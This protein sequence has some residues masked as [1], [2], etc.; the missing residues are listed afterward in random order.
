M[1]VVTRRTGERIVIGTTIRVEVL[2]V[3]G[4][5]VRIGIQ[6][7]RGVTILRQELLD[8]EVP[9]TQPASEVESY[10]ERGLALCE[11]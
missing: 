11:D 9:G 10:P 3:S 4:S 6:A 7:P 5:R 8:R 2:E 1:L